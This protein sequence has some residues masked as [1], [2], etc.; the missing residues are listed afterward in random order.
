M[1]FAYLAYVVQSFCCVIPNARIIILYVLNRGI[2][3]FAHVRFDMSAVQA[4]G[5]LIFANFCDFEEKFDDFGPIFEFSM[6][7]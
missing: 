5:Y 2:Y 7:F 1:P 4:N 3:N 6:R